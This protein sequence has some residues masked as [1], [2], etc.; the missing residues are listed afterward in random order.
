MLHLNELPKIAV[1]ITDWENCAAFLG[2]P[3]ED[4][5]DIIEENGRVRN[6]RIAM[7]QRWKE[8]KG[9]EATYL[10]L[11]ESLA[12][13]GRRDLVEFI[14]SPEIKLPMTSEVKEEEYFNVMDEGSCASP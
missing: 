8:L 4:V 2:I 9:R 6:R 13:M 1:R 10:N 5:N 7:L 14:L 12:Q 11:M 3:R